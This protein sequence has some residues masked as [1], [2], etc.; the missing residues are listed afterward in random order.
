MK[1]SSH[2]CSFLLARKA[3]LSLWCSV[4]ELWDIRV[5][6]ITWCLSLCLLQREAWE[7]HCTPS[8][9]GPLWFRGHALISLHRDTKEQEINLHNYST[10][11]KTNCFKFVFLGFFSSVFQVCWTDSKLM[12]RVGFTRSP[13]DCPNLVEIILME[14]L[15]FFPIAGKWWDPN[16]PYKSICPFP[17]RPSREL[18]LPR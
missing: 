12:K 5:S 2:V 3:S 7:R 8:G 18:R 16:P 9:S 10:I 1:E 13:Y 15:K 11:C 6:L 4:N 14:T 17:T